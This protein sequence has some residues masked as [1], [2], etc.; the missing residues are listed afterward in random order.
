MIS[1]SILK[2]FSL[3]YA[4][5]GLAIIICVASVE[6]ELQLV[7]VIFRHGDR[8][9]DNND[10]ERYPNDPYL[11]SDF[12]PMGRGQL[13]NQGKM[14][15]FMLGKVLRERYSEFLG[16]VYMPQSVWGIS[17]D[18]DRTKMSLQL[19]LAGLFPPN[20]L[21]KWNSQLNWQPIPTQYLSHAEDNLFLGDTCPSYVAEYDR[22][23]QTPQVSSQLSKYSDFMK[24]LTQWTGKN[25]ST[26]WD[27]YYLYHTLMAEYSMGYVLPSWAYEIFPYGRLWN[28]TLLSYEVANFSP[29]ERRL[30]AGPYLQKVTKAMLDFTTG[31]LN[32]ERKIY[33]YSGHESNIAGVLYAL[34]VNYPHIPEYSSSVILELHQIDNEYYVQVLYYLGI[35]S[36]I[37]KLQLPGCAELCPLD[38]YL[39]LTE[40]VM[41]SPEE[42]FCDKSLT[43][44]YGNQRSAEEIDLARYNLIRTAK[45]IKNE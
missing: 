13:T 27:M 34:N 39:E 32:D 11:D 14:R 24:Q 3:M 31:T 20:R 1:A 45:A 22:V 12:Y 19:V 25:I 26:V 43:Q 23:L 5:I 41:P 28:G 15:E 42:L 30:F 29:L 7:N 33:L 38:K 18:Y 9:P 2:S 16:D 21:Q 6:A 36:K 17:S 10:G 44:G 4:I 40:E 37:I 8:T 35:P